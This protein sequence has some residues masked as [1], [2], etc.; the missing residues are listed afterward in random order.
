M[1]QA[2]ELLM[3]GQILNAII[4]VYTTPL[5]SGFY[6]LLLI[7]TVAM[8]YIK[9]QSIRVVGLVMLVMSAMVIP[10]IRVGMFQG[11]MFFLLAI[12]IAMIIYSLMRK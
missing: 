11:V 3:N 7:L 9:T 1:T 4:S 2:F 12:S 8:V 10:Y 5:G 6:F